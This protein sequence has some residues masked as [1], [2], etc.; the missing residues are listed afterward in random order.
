MHCMVAGCEDLQERI[1]REKSE[2]TKTTGMTAGSVRSKIRQHY[3]T[4]VQT[5][6]TEGTEM[7][8]PCHLRILHLPHSLAFV[9]AWRAVV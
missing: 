6:G 5:G 8:I 7:D 3:H 2:H 1:K 4:K 9:Q